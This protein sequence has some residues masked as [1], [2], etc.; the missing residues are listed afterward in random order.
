MLTSEER[1]AELHRRMKVL[2]RRQWRR[3]YRLVSGT[4]CAAC[5][6]VGILLAL[7]IS[8]MP[9]QPL[10]AMPEGAAANVFASHAAL[11][12]IVV[13]LVA[14]SLGAMVTVLCSRIKRHM[15]EEEER[16][17]REL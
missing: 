12:Y 1:V 11:G 4:A 3:R 6:G 13:M 16:D 10:A 14:F 17:D 8:R 15:E 5:L 7:D 2:R 9:V